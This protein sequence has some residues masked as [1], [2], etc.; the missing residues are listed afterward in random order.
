MPRCGRSQDAGAQ[1]FGHHLH[2]TGIQ[3][4]F[5]GDLLVRQ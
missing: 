3:I 4:E 2:V 1:L 5:A